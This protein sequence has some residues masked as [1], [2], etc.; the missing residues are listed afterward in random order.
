MERAG[1]DNDGAGVFSCCRCWFNKETR[2]GH[3]GRKGQLRLDLPD[4]LK[5]FS[6]ELIIFAWSQLS[7]VKITSPWLSFPT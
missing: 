2:Q 5:R 3:T 1:R 4:S 6:E 7:V